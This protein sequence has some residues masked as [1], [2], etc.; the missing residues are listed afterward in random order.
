M[1]KKISYIHKQCTSNNKKINQD[2]VEILGKTFV[3][4]LLNDFD[5][6]AKEVDSTPLTGTFS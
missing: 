2:L 1:K 5:E 6:Y 4:A 3:L